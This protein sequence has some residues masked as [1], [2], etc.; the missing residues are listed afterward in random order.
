MFAAL[1]HVPPQFID[2]EYDHIMTNIP[3]TES[4]VEFNNYMFEQWFNNPHAGYMWNC[5]N[6][7]HRTTNIVVL[8][9]FFKQ[10]HPKEPSKYC[11][12]HNKIKSCC[13]IL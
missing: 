5:N 6:E 2:Y 10:I 9:Q 3:V 7:H 12:V 8:V 4:I 11:G 13:K 1:A